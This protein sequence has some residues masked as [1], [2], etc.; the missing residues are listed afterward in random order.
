MRGKFTLSQN[1][2]KAEEVL[3]G[4][5]ENLKDVERRILEL[6]RNDSLDDVTRTSETIKLSYAL[7][8]AKKLRVKQKNFIKNKKPYMMNL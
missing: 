7:N 4:R 8:H 2:L 5:K 6:K 1:M 3:S